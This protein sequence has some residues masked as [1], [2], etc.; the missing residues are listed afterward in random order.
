A[1]QLNTFER[2]HSMKDKA[3]QKSKPVDVFDFPDNSDVSS[4]GRPG[5]DEKDEEPNETF[6]PPLHSTAIYADEEEFS[7]HCGLCIPSTSPEKEAKR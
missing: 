3:G 7:K 6:D 5:E 4:V 1:R 2:T